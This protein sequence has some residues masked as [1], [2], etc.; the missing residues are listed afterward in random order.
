MERKETF[1]VTRDLV[2][3]NSFGTV[4][5]EDGVKLHVTVGIKEDEAYGWFE[6][7]DIKSTGGD[8]YAEGGLWMEGKKVVDY[9]G[10]FCLPDFVISKLKSWG[11]DTSE[12]EL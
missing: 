5:A 8:W 6:C 4:G 1:T 2:L 7:Y 3:E 9:D 10:V 11:Y 12:V